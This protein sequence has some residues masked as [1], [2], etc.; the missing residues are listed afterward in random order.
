MKVLVCVLGQLRFP[1]LTW[2]HFK[3]YVLDELKADLVTCGPD[4]NA[5]NDYTRNAKLNILSEAVIP[6]DAK[7]NADAVLQHRRNMYDT[8]PKNYDQYILT[9]GDHMWVGPHPK[10]H[11]GVSW[12][13]NCEFHLGISDR[14]WVF[15]RAM[16]EKYTRDIGVFDE[17]FQ[18]VEQ[19]MYGKV[20]WGPLT[21]LAYFPMYLTDSDG[22]HRRPDEMDAPTKHYHW[23]FYI[24]HGYLSKNGMFCGR[25]KM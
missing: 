24:D 21:G 2:P 6:P 20:E 23:P 5:V 16:L 11:H 4:A 10:L 3:K 15:P 14:H 8:V 7:C 1:E 18:N 25:I 13:M 19:Y 12:F 17:F 22:K 9:R